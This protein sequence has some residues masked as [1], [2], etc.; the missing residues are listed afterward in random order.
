[1]FVFTG[2]VECW[3]YFVA[4]LLVGG[5]LVFLGLRT[6]W[7]VATAVGSLVMAAA[8]S[9]AGAATAQ[10]QDAV[11]SEV[12]RLIDDANKRA[13]ALK[14]DLGGFANQ[15][16][17]RGNPYQA[18]AARLAAENQARVRRGFGM[19]GG[20]VFGQAVGDPLAGPEQEGVLYVAVSFSMPPAALKALATEAQTIGGK[21]VIRGL[22]NGSFEQTLAA[23][24]QVFDP[25]SVAGI[26]IEPQVFRAYRVT[27]V[28]TFIVATAPVT[29]CQDGVDCT[30]AAT[31]HDKISGN[32]TTAEAL[33]QLALDGS[34][35]P[36]VARS[37]L[38]DLQDR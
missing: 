35:A 38:A 11:S 4:G 28:P 24:K 17:T 14:S 19:I 29:P 9:W 15:V 7:V 37:F 2:S 16:E 31:P 27:R 36:N 3:A 34:E 32:I 6:R 21:V 33:R 23:A 13:E 10:S 8:I 25:Q 1:M 26:A 30:S 22:V 20:D 5:T 12:R 18:E